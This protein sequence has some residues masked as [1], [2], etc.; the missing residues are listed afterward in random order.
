MRSSDD[1][2]GAMLYLVVGAPGAGKTQT[3]GAL[4]ELGTRYTALDMD[5]LI[6]SASLLAGRDIHFDASSWRAYH[7]L[8]FDL[9]DALRLNRQIPVLFAPFDPG[10]FEQGLPRGWAGAEWLLLD[11]S[12]ATRRQ[13]LAER[14][15]PAS[16]VA[17]ALADAAELR[18]RVPT[19]LDTDSLDAQAAAV[20]VS[21]WLD[22]SRPSVARDRA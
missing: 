2:G 15:W 13:R 8:W 17:E 1:S 9:L 11:C 19:R 22:A 5:M 21:D 18:L 20:A 14:N 6:E 7:A 12:D 4:L 16:R 10:E 3:C